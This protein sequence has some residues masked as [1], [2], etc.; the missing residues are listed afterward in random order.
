MPV[1]WTIVMNSLFFVSY[2]FPVWSEGDCEHVRVVG[3]GLDQLVLVHVPQLHCA[4]PRTR[5]QHRLFNTQT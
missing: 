1:I 3:V 2:L 4:V 5:R